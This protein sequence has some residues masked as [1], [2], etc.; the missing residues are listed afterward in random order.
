MKDLHKKYCIEKYDENGLICDFKLNYTD[1]FNFAFDVIDVIGKNEPDR[2]AL[3]W[4]NEEG[5]E[6]SFTYSDLMKNSNQVANMFLAHGVKK[7][8]KVVCVS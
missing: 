3:L 6:H 8:D 1:N 4:I 7:G 2:R 5:E